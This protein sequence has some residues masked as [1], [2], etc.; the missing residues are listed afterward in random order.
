MPFLNDQELENLQQEIKDLNSKNEELENELSERIEEVGDV[1]STARN[2]NILLSF[3]AGIA[4]AFAVYFYKNGAGANLGKIKKQEAN[5]VLDSIN[6][7]NDSDSYD[8]NEDS[9][10]EN[11]DSYENEDSLSDNSTSTTEAIS[12]IKQ[13]IKGETVYS[14][15][16]GAFTEKSYPLLSE[17]FTAILSNGEYLRYSIG[18]FKTLKEAQNF[19]KQLLKMGFED[20][21]VASFINGN[22]QQIHKPY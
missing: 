3:L 14:V 19:R 22:R 7:A 17:S 2:R 8:E 13:N 15:Q 18:V 11:E 5:R 16:I 6:D 20:A 21:F 4:I 12:S 1:K 9:Y 10:D